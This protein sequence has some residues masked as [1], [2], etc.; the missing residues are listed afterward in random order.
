MLAHLIVRLTPVVGVT[1]AGALVSVATVCAVV[2]RTLL[3]RWIGDRDRRIAAAVNFGV[4]ALGVVLL[5]LGEGWL[6]LTAGC[7]LFGLGIGNLTSLPPLIAQ[8]E[9]NRG[10]VV[11]VVALIVAINQGVF[12]FAPAIIGVLRDAASSYV[13][14][15]ALV[16]CIQ[17]IAAMIV[18]GGRVKKRPLVR[19]CRRWLFRV[20]R[21]A[22]DVKKA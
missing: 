19:G 1:G 11:T 10:D 2:G 15:F 8:K 6:V 14:P 22:S 21:V 3:G 16:A 17:L 18:V 9:F 7:V 20:R 4:Q 5:I 13:A 12:A